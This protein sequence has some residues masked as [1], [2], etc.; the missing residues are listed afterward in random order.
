MLHIA[1]KASSSYTCIKTGQVVKKFCV[2]PGAGFVILL[3]PFLRV[4]NVH[5]LAC[6]TTPKMVMYLSSVSRVVNSES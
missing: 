2:L 1:E 5:L 4:E 3:L 6:G